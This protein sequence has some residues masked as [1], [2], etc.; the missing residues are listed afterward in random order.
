M[1]GA[2]SISAFPLFSGFVSKSMVMDA[3]ASGHM[4][5]VWFVLLFASAGVFHHA[6]IKIPFFAFFSHDS[7]MRPREAPVHMLLAMGITAALCIFI[8]SYPWPLYRLLPYPDVVYQPYTGG[9]I[10]GQSQLLFFSALAFTLL[11]LSGIYPAEMRGV[12]LDADWFYRKGGRLFFRLADRV[13]NGVNAVS[14]RHIAVGTAR[15]AGRLSTDATARAALI[16]LV[17]L[18]LLTGIRGKRLDILKTRTYRDILLGT[19]PVGI[20]IGMAAML[21]IVVFIMT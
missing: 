18:W 20:G 16:P 3:A 13:F 19:I 14:D 15:T 6:G 5:A 1:V 11:L 7:G 8:G 12:N 21:L 9:H 4:T 10:L 17:S 2:A